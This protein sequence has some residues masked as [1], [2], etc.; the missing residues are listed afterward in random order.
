M[1]RKNLGVDGGVSCTTTSNWSSPCSSTV[2]RYVHARQYHTVII[3]PGFCLLPGHTAR[4][5]C[6][7]YS[8]LI[9]IIGEEQILVHSTI[10][11]G[12]DTNEKS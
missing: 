11:Y 6:R 5:I 7:N 10:C 4:A 2:R 1:R 12:V 9:A 3:L 8:S